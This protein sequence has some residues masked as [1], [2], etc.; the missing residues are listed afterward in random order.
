MA[1]SGG[2]LDTCKWLA[3]LGADLHSTVRPSLRPF[4]ITSLTYYCW[5]GKVCFYQKKCSTWHPSL[6][7]S[8]SYY[9]ANSLLKRTGCESFLLKSFPLSSDVLYPHPTPFCAWEQS[10]VSHPSS[11]DFH[12]ET[13]VSPH[14]HH[15]I[16]QRSM[17]S[18]MWPNGCSTITLKSM[19]RW[20]GGCSREFEWKGQ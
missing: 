12:F 17:A 9:L 19:Q 11:N 7:L 3:K 14:R 5:Q 8:L 15:F 4:I 6:F 18:A 1:S 10:D 2:H 16:G 20:V 13:D